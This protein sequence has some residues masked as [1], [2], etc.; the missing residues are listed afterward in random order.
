MPDGRS[1]YRLLVVSIVLCEEGL[2]LLLTEKLK[3]AIV[4]LLDKRKA[5]AHLHI[6][7]YAGA[8]LFYLDKSQ[9]IVTITPE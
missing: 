4:S 2:D 6:F 9:L 5:L 3:L 8:E 7:I 1:G